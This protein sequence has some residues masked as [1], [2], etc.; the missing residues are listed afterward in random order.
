[1]LICWFVNSHNYQLREIISKNDTV[2]VIMIHD[3]KGHTITTNYFCSHT[4]FLDLSHLQFEIAWRMRVN[5]ETKITMYGF[6][7]NLWWLYSV[8][9]VS[10][11]YSALNKFCVIHLSLHIQAAHFAT[12]WYRIYF[13]KR[14]YQKFVL[15]NWN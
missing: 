10:L 2:I 15:R 7:N 3:Q 14:E 5:R 9:Y 13:S 6:K 1:M 12:T 8:M 4:T 11:I